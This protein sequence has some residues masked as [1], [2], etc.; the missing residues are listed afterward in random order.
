MLRYFKKWETKCSFEG[1]WLSE[2]CHIIGCDEVLI[3]PLVT[4]PIVE[5]F[6]L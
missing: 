4:G 1:H 2:E 6:I 5:L 3:S